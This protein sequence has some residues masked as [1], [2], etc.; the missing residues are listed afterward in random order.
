MRLA[1]S[2]CHIKPVRI[3]DDVDLLVKGGSHYLSEP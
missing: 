1:L 2:W 3:P